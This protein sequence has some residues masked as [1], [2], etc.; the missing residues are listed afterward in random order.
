MAYASETDLDAKWGAEAVTLAAYDPISESRDETRILAALDAASSIMD[1]Y[2]ARRYALP[3]T[4]TTGGATLLRNVCCDLAIGQLSNTPGSRNE[5]VVDAEKRAIQFLR[6]V[7]DAKAAIPLIPA[8]GAPADVS[9]NE[10]VM[11]A[12]DRTFTRHRMRGL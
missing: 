9:P 10:A 6:D 8:P 4:A 7:A 1:G 11:I 3:L 5:I 12:D 2:L